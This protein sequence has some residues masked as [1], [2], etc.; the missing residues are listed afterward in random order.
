MGARE[1]TLVLALIMVGVLAAVVG[2]TR[3][4]IDVSLAAGRCNGSIGDCL[5]EAEFEADSESTRRILQQSGY[6]S[7]IATRN[8]G[9]PAASPARRNTRYVQGCNAYQRCKS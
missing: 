8:S 4:E 2:S 3:V 9:R 1:T 6:I 7:Y 5:G